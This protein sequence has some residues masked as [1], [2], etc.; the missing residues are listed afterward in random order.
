MKLDDPLAQHVLKETGR[1]AGNASALIFKRVRMNGKAQEAVA[2]I[3]AT[4]VV[5]VVIVTANAIAEDPSKV[6]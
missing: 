6:H 2:K 1:L 5:D 3:V 4:L